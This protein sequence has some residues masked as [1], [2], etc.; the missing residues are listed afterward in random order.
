LFVIVVVVVVSWQVMGVVLVLS[1]YPWVTFFPL[2]M[3]KISKKKN[4][5][6]RTNFLWRRNRRML[7]NIWVALFYFSMWSLSK[8]FNYSTHIV[9]LKPW[10]LIIGFFFSFVK[11]HLFKGVFSQLKVSSFVEATLSTWGLGG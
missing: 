9:C 7:S 4:L 10:R 11:T 2:E 8:L 3:L 5:F 6:Q 1:K